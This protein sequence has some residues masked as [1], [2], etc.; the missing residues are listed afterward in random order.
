MAENSMQALES[1][2]AGSLALTW[3]VQDG[4]RVRLH[5]WTAACEGVPLSQ[6]NEARGEIAKGLRMA[7]VS[8]ISLSF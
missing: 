7:Y 8:M 5:P 2:R 1:G 6:L 3:V 4:P